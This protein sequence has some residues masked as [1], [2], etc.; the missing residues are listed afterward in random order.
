MNAWRLVYRNMLLYRRTKL[1]F[2]TGF[3]EPVLYLFSIGLGVGSLISGFS[4]DGRT[5]GY[6]AFVAP[7]M[8]ASSAM[9]GA[10]L[11]ATYGVFFRLKY[12]KL[13][14]AVLATP[15]TTGDVATGETLWSLIRGGIYSAAFLAVM[16]A[17]GLVESWWGLAALPATLLIGFAF[18]GLGMWLTTYMTSWQDFEIVTLA[19]M[20]MTLFS[21][22][23]FPVTTLAAPLRWAIEVTPLYRGVALCRELTTGSLTVASLVSVLYLGVL[24]AVGMAA[25]RRRLSVLLLT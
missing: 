24:G 1:V 5:I 20:P 12:D 25:A 16:T 7:A 6:A 18:A 21:G 14:D 19:L 10:I 11:D 2:L 9:N 22:T 17:M 3:L 23:F 8:L 13:Y 15:L 4:V